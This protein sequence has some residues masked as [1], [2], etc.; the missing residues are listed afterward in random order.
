[1]ASKQ[2][3]YLS[4]FWMLR[5]IRSKALTDSVSDRVLIP[6]SQLAT[7]LGGSSHAE[8]DKR[9]LWDLFYKDT[10]PIHGNSILVT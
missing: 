4:Q 6:G 2:Q 1:M 10:N 8:R 9:V 3:I 5:S 7:L